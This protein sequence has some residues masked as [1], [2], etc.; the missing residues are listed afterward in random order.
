MTAIR[1]FALDELSTVP[2]AKQGV[3]PRLTGVEEY[4]ARRIRTTI[5]V[6]ED[7]PVPRRRSKK[8]SSLVIVVVLVIL[9]IFIF[10]RINPHGAPQTQRIS[11]TH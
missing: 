10:G 3:C 11:V 9:A 6:R 4:M 5:T 7:D 8:K 2:F 1:E